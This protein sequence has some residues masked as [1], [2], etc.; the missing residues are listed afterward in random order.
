[1]QPEP[2]GSTQGYPLVSVEVLRA[3]IRVVRLVLVWGRRKLVVLHLNL[4]LPSPRP[5]FHHGQ[6]CPPIIPE[7]VLQCDRRSKDSHHGTR[8]V[9]RKGRP[10]MIRTSSSS[11]ISKTTKSTEKRNLFTLTKR[12]S[13]APIEY[14]TDRSASWI[15]ILH[16]RQ[17]LVFVELG[18]G[19]TGAG[20]IS[21][22]DSKGRRIWLGGFALANCGEDLGEL[23]G[24]LLLLLFVG[25][26]P[27][28]RNGFLRVF[29][30]M[31][32]F[33][34]WMAFGGNIRDLGSIREETDK[35]TTPHQLS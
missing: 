10:K 6:L 17:S 19:V 2:E 7:R 32:A 11:S 9:T 22:R 21:G 12:L 26:S 15:L 1:I 16:R 31:D 34:T 23:R 28:M 18:K 20:S 25:C 5:T 4:L 35:T 3:F 14:L 27:M 13:Q 8:A 29:L 24:R 33:S 30:S